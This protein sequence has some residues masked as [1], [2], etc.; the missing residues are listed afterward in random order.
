ME[1]NEYQRK[2][3]KTSRAAERRDPQSS[4][5]AL[6]G[7]ASEVGAIL[8]VFKRYVRDDSMAS[9]DK[10]IISTELGD[11]LW[12]VAAIASTLDLELDDIAAAN[13]ERAQ[14]R[15]GWWLGDKIRIP[16]FD[17]GW[18]RTERFPRCLTIEFRQVQRRGKKLATL[19]LKDAQ[20]NAFPE[21][22]ITRDGK[23]YGYTVDA[24]LGASLTDNSRRIDDYRFHD[25]I[26]MG[27]MAVLG[28]SPTMRALLQVKRRSDPATDEEQDGAR[29]VFLEEGLAAVLAK[30]ARSKGDFQQEGMVDGEVLD[31][32][33]AV[34][35]DLEVQEVQAAL[36]RKAISEGFRA[37]KQLGRN[38]GGFLVADL[39]EH[40]LT[41]HPQYVQRPAHRRQAGK[42][43][44]P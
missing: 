13:I 20:P 14:D 10:E 5:A 42:R 18:P 1:L 12:Y 2:A 7:L 37:M 4:H 9:L 38:G 40:S 16:I 6:L 29:A 41:Y 22:S 31:V 21:G 28:W 35:S 32:V 15:Y 25:A 23:Q 24:Q 8:D 44:R 34:V 26:H 43:R 19:Y 33:R 39:D 30:L 11:T 27:F 36:W 17:K 3:L